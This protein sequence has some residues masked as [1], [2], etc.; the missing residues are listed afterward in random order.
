MVGV[1]SP[2]AQPGDQSQE[3]LKDLPEAPKAAELRPAWTTGC[4]DSKLGPGSPVLEGLWF[5]SLPGRTKEISVVTGTQPELLS[6]L[7]WLAFP[8]CCFTSHTFSPLPLDDWLKLN[9]LK[10][11]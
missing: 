11:H 1:P 5:Q 2:G 7:T 6:F 10:L 9:I 4:L 8:V 3:T